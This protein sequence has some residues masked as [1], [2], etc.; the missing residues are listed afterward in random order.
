MGLTLTWNPRAYSYRESHLQIFTVNTDKTGIQKISR[1][2]LC[3][4]LSFFSIDFLIYRIWNGLFHCCWWNPGEP[5]LRRKE[6]ASA[7]FCILEMMLH[8]KRWP[9]LKLEGFVK[10]QC[11]PSL[12][13][14][15]KSKT[16]LRD[17][18]A[19]WVSAFE[20]PNPMDLWTHSCTERLDRGPGQTSLMCITILMR[21]IALA[22]HG[23]DAGRTTMA[24]A[25]KTAAKWQARWPKALRCLRAVHI[26]FCFV[27]LSRVNRPSSKRFLKLFASYPSSDFGVRS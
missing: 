19:A 2:T 22:R 8:R 26:F 18:T 25:L 11:G 17:N 10:L 24:V 3:S 1:I 5:M 6:Q 4:K 14:Q 12:A 16:S 20:F 23:C 15:M 9:A 21:L 7:H 27:A 13:A